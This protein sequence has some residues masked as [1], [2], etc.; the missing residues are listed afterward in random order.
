M[1][2]VDLFAGLGGFTEGATRA[3]VQ[4]VWAANHW[5]AA[6]DVHA[7]NHPHTD[8]ACQ[9]L[10]Q[11]DWGSVPAHDLLLASPACQ[12]HSRTCRPQSETLVLQSFSHSE[13]QP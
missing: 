5:K 9:D 13:I 3:G 8:H 10:R 4:V 1:R 6:V 12:G 2:A 7:R 11:A